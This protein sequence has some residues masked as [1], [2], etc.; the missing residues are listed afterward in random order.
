MTEAPVEF[1]LGTGIEVAREGDSPRGS[2]RGRVILLAGHWGHSA[3]SHGPRDS[4]NKNT[5]AKKAT[6]T[7]GRMSCLA[8]KSRTM[9]GNLEQQ[10]IGFKEVRLKSGYF[11]KQPWRGGE[12]A[13]FLSV[14]IG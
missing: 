4:K 5:V 6:T 14:T 7:R 9:G 13:I 10:G 12:S 3:R 8:V 2:L 11:T 1:P